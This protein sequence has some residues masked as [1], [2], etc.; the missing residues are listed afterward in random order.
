[1]VQENLT[2][3]L[4]P[5]SPQARGSHSRVP[6]WVAHDPR[7]RLFKTT[8]LFSLL[9]CP[10]PILHHACSSAHWS[11]FSCLASD[12]AQ[13]PPVERIAAPKP[14]GGGSSTKSATATCGRNMKGLEARRLATTRDEPAAPAHRPFSPA[15]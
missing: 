10:Y 8:M 2:L 3:H 9:A 15:S 11:T 6:P 1:M 14:A 4:G 12:S 7:L 13:Q 5:G